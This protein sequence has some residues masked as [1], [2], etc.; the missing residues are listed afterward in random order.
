MEQYWDHPKSDYTLQLLLLCRVISLLL[1]MNDIWLRN[2]PFLYVIFII[3]I[4]Y[5]IFLHDPT[6]TEQFFGSQWKRWNARTSCLY[7]VKRDKPNVG[8]AERSSALPYCL[9]WSRSSVSGMASFKGIPRVW[10]FE[11]DLILEIFCGYK[12]F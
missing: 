12:F 3:I 11:N 9:A 6:D 8:L 5:T 10:T 4:T 1:E 2:Q 7:Q